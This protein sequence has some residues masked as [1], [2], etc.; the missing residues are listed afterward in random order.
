[1]SVIKK[2]TTHEK[3]E[4]FL[5]K[6][7]TLGSLDDAINSAVE[8]ID[9]LTQRNFIADTSA[10]A[11]TF[12]GSSGQ[13]LEIDECVEITK[14]ERGLDEYGDS[15]EEISAG[16]LNGYYLKPANYA[17]KSRP[18]TT[19][20]LRDRYW[21]AGMQNCRITAKWGFSASVPQGIELATTVLAGGIYNYNR[22]GASG[23]IKSEKICNYS[24]TYDNESG[25]DAW[26]R[27][28]QLIQ[29]YK[30]YVL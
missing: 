20:H 8:L 10:S 3:I 30:R 22:G 15:Y 26:D 25:W 21:L 11:R 27:A 28:K 7:I 13:D 17:A 2:Y 18:I 29:T 23:N 4:G 14:V 12:D 1:M 9:Q 6:T 24:V 19:V 16:G 5:N